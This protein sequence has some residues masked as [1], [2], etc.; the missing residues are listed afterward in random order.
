MSTP[1]AQ[2]GPLATL[3]YLGLARPVLILPVLAGL[4]CEPYLAKV[5]GTDCTGQRVAVS[6]QGVATFAT[7]QGNVE[8][9]VGNTPMPN[10]VCIVPITNDQITAC[11]HGNASQTSASTCDVVNAVTSF[12][13]RLPSGWSLLGNSFKQSLSVTAMYG[14]P[15]VA[16]SVWKWDAATSKWQFFTPLLDGAA[17]ATYAADRGYGVLSE[18]GPGEG[19][20]V[21]VKH[22]SEIVQAG[23][24]FSPTAPD[25]V[26]GW[27]L[28]T[29]SDNTTPA[30]FHAKLKTAQNSAG[31]VTLW[32]WENSKANWY[33]YAPSLDEQG[34][35]VLSNYIN[36]K[37]YLDFDKTGKTLGPGVGFWVNRP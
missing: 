30:A 11:S 3:A 27:N 14:S 12:S 32:A 21:N 1:A 10:S 2:C 33:F 36:S 34:P 8:F 37:R 13:A 19:Y 35:G 18:I 20:W 24:S 9:V 29:T 25:L 7:S 28:S 23:L 15:D 22:Q 17:L 5:Y 4:V 6:A 16:T 31:V 26:T